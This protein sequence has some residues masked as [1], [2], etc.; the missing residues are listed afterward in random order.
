[1]ASS[2]ACCP[3]SK[4]WACRMPSGAC[5]R[6][7]GDSRIQLPTMHPQPELT[8]GSSATACF[9]MSV[10]LQSQI[11][12]CQTTMEWQLQFRLPMHPPAAQ[13]FG[14]CLLPSFPIPFFPPGLQG[15][16]PPSVDN[17]P[18]R[19]LMKVPNEPGLSPNNGLENVFLSDQFMAGNPL[20]GQ[21]KCL[22]AKTTSSQCLG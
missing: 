22:G 2:Q 11:S 6:K 15:N 3:S 7:Q 12:S 4:P 10:Q 21:A 20:K 19:Q 18:V 13:G 8:D 14:Q 17:S 5:I 9:Q 1:M 16:C